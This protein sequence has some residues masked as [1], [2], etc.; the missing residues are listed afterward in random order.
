MGRQFV[1]VVALLLIAGVAAVGWIAGTRVRSPES[2]AA[3]AAPPDPS[4]ITAPVERRVLSSRVVTRGDVVPGQSATVTG[5]ASEDDLVV[6][7]VFA[8]VGD[9]LLEGDRVV[10]V[11]G[12]PVVV[13]E[14]AV[15]AFRAMRPGM[16]GTDIEQ[17]QAALGRLGCDTADDDGVYAEATK[18]CVTRLYDALGYD[19]VP[20]SDTEAAD[21]TDARGA[22]TDAEEALHEAEAALAEASEGPTV[23][24]LV[25]ARNDVDAAVME[26][27][28][29]L[30]NR[31]STPAD[32]ASKLAQL[33]LADA[34][35]AELT[36]APDV[37]TET[38]A[39]EQ[40]QAA[41]DR[42]TEA[43][44]ELEAR[45][46]PTVP[47]G[48]AVFVDALPATV[49]TLNAE[50]GRAV[51]DSSGDGGFFGNQSDSGALAVLATA[52]L[53][54]ETL[55]PPSDA[56]LVQVGMDV[57]LLDEVSG[58]TMAATLT[59]LGE[60]VESG[61]G[62]GGSRG[63]KAVVETDEPLPRVW[64]GRNVRVT[65]TAA[66]T[67][68]EVLVVPA[69][70][71]SSGADGEARVQVLADDGTV[72]NVIVEPGLSAEGF[73]EI[74]PVEDGSLHEGDLVIVGSGG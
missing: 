7:A 40:A 66:A 57:E 15:P 72:T 19:L 55:V 26:L 13:L 12:R 71:L 53:Q 39:V 52:G 41:L 35:L 67:D 69:A 70:A 32:R 38:A 27:N 31:E 5:P 48:E 46:G 2:A 33:E 42:A 36:E 47:L 45:S 64:T 59:S 56:D 44:Q 11:S 23:S 65:F 37:E 8:D 10:E 30:A 25:S 73:V 63:F 61:S 22:V 20:T 74:V 51:G 6:T 60:Q 16:R 49:S 68:S 50:I 14:G 29:E 17:L 34:Q 21:L 43:L 9:E 62:D 3:K 4:P 24:E 1:A 18:Q 58:D 28:A 54:V